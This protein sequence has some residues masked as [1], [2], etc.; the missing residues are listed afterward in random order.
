MKVMIELPEGLLEEPQAAN[1]EVEREFYLS[2]FA[3]GKISKH[4][5]RERLG[6]DRWSLDTLLA[7][8]NLTPAYTLDEAEADAATLTRVLS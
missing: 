3:R 4:Q 7:E 2:L 5:L 6:L 8:R 1:R